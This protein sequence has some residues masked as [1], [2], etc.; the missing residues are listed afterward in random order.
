MLK[1]KRSP[2]AEA[3]CISFTKRRKKRWRSMRIKRVISSTL[4]LIFVMKVGR[5]L[6]TST[7]G[8]SKF[9]KR[10]GLNKHE[11]SKQAC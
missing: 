8:A 9:I 2:W 10:T 1:G 11:A 5:N 6:L 7:F 3:P 4:Y